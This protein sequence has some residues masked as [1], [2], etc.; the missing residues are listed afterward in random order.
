MVNFGKIFIVDLEG[1]ICSCREWDLTGVPC[2]HARLALINE[3][4]DIYVNEYYSGDLHKNVCKGDYT[5][6]R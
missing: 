2:V 1:R 6:T 5:N 3:G 4:K